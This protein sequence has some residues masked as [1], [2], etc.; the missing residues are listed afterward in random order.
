MPGFEATA[1][2]VRAACAEGSSAK[3]VIERLMGA[4]REFAG[5]EPQADDMTCVAVRV[6]R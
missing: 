6:E 1:T 3:E 2:T 4:A 5:D